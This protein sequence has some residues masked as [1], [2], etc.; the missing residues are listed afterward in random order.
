MDNF[1]VFIISYKR[2]DRVFTLKALKKCG[3]TG[4]WFIVVGEDDE[5]KDEYVKKY[6]ERVVFFDK[7]DYRWVD[8]FDNKYE[9]KRTPVFA[10]N[11]VY[12]LAE[13]LGFNYFLVLDDDYSGFYWMCDSK[14]NYKHLLI[15]NLNKF[16][17]SFLEFYKNTNFDVIA[18]AQTGDFLGGKFTFEKYVFEQGGVRKAMNFHLCSVKRRVFWISRLNDDVNTYVFWGNKGKLFI[19]NYMVSLLQKLTQSNKGGI[20]EAYRDYGTYI[21]AL[22]TVMC[23]PS[24]VFVSMMGRK[25]RRMHHQIYWDRIVPKIIKDL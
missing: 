24:G 18:I 8:L 12:D 11:A 4:K 14:G 3:F 6:K 22:S 13:K 1:C 2:P 23:C 16:L 10:R 25:D 21:K 19:T 15:K 7:K 20:T 5:R 9:D 17:E